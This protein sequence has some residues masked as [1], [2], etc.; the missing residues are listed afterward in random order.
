MSDPNFDFNESNATAKSIVDQILSLPVEE[1]L[2]PNCLNRTIRNS[3]TI[4]VDDF[5]N[6]INKAIVKHDGA[7]EENIV[8]R[9][10]ANR[11]RS[12]VVI[13]PL[14]RSQSIQSLSSESLESPK[15]E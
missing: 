8:P 11:T 12:K 15:T 14:R 6:K 2:W 9:S 4:D 10:A 5:V 13:N 7:I 1:R 3:S